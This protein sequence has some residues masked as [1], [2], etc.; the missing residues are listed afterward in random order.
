MG[1]RIQGRIIEKAG[2]KIE[3]KGGGREARG[4]RTIRRRRRDIR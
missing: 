3:R 4:I 2:E 1:D